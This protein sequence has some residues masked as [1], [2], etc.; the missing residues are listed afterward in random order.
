MTSKDN[1]KDKLIGS[2]YNSMPRYLSS[3][4]RVHKLFFKKCDNEIT[5][6]EHC[7][8]DKHWYDYI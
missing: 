8:G 6:Y 4:H 5:H 1:Y 7:L 2:I 3:R